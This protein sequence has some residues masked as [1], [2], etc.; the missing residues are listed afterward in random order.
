MSSVVSRAVIVCIL[1]ASC[2]AEKKQ[3]EL[4]HNLKDFIIRRN[5]LTLGNAVQEGE[6]FFLYGC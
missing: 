4:M 6:T 1:Y 2:L 5:L 3:R